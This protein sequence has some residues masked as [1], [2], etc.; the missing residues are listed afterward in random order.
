MFSRHKNST[1][2]TPATCW[3][4]PAVDREYNTRLKTNFQRGYDNKKISYITS[5]GCSSYLFVLFYRHFFLSIEEFISATPMK[6]KQGNQIHNEYCLFEL[7][8]EQH[9]RH[10]FYCH[11]T[12]RKTKEFLSGYVNIICYVRYKYSSSS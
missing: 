10:A 3:C 6:K 2:T 12:N 5:H 11:R 7:I 4:L 1:A 9:S 8:T